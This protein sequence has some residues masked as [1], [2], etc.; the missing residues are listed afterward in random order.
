MSAPIVIVGAG[1]AGLAAARVLAARD[2]D[3]LLLEA[4]ALRRETRPEALTVGVGGAGLYS[5]GKLSF[6]PAAR[7][8]WALPDQRALALA[9]AWVAARLAEVGLR[10]EPWAEARR[11]AALSPTGF[12]T[13]PCRR[14]SP[15]R[16]SALIEALYAPLTSRIWLNAEA[17]SLKRRGEGLSIEVRHEGRLRQVEARAVIWA[18]GRLGPLALPQ[19]APWLPLEFL[20]LELGARLEAATDHPFFEALWREAGGLDPKLIHAPRPGLEWRTFCGCLGGEVLTARQ[21]GLIS[22]SGRADGPL[23]ALSNIG[24]NAR[25]TAPGPSPWAEVGRAAFDLPL[26]G[27]RVEALPLGRA[28]APLLEGLMW[29]QGRYPSLAEGEVWLRG[30][31]IEGVGAYPTLDG[32]LRSPAAPVFVAGDACGR[33]RGLLAALVSGAFVGL[34]QG[35]P[36]TPGEA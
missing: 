14:L 32:A 29:L 3:F 13:Y 6:A 28:S 23:G 7:A 25:L 21:Q 30:P 9:Y 19:I 2:V 26:R 10:A 24:F 4:G 35:G 5:D 31:T 1:P 22:R 12:K 16:R 34:L 33:F 36:H 27:L 11:P 20:R 18:T 17:L 8:L 15:P